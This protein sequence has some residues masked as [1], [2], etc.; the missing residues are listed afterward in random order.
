MLERFYPDLM[1]D[2]VED[3]DLNLLKAK[4]IKGLILDIDNTLVPQFT[5]EAGDN[6]VKWI[7]RVKASGINAC[8]VSNASRVRVEKFNERLGIHAIH[9][10]TKPSVKAFIRAVKL[11]DISL[12]EAA[13]IGDQLFTDI[14]GGN[15]LDMFTILVKPIDANEILFV[16]LKR[17]IER[18][19]LAKHSRTYKNEKYIN[20]RQDW[21][22]KS[23]LKHGYGR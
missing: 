2:R 21:R 7:A 13:V 11:M 15:K 22:K 23:A 3:V 1:L 19:V 6:I 9:R 14:Y 17:H 4:G 12:K 20:K 8:I 16:R 5:K 18:F 10:A